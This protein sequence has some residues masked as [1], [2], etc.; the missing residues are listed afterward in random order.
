MCLDFMFGHVKAAFILLTI[1][2]P[3]NIHS[4]ISSHPP[5]KIAGGYKKIVKSLERLGYETPRNLLSMFLLL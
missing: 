3:K 4:W 2:Y 1:I 5:R